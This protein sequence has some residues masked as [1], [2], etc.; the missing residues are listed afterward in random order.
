MK[1]KVFKVIIYLLLAIFILGLSVFAYCSFEGYQMYQNALKE[2]SI[3]ERINEI[4]SKEDYVTIDKIP[5]DFKYAI[6]AVEDHRFEEHGAVDV[7]AI[8]R[9]IY[10]NITEFQLIEG[11]STITQQFAKNTFFTQERK[12][13]RKMA[14]IFAAIDLEKM[15]SK[16]DIVEMY[17][18]TIYYGD[19][20]YGIGEASR[21]YFDKEPMDLTLDEITLLAGLPNA[22]S[23]YSL[24]NSPELARERQL[25]VIY[26]MEAYGF[27]TEEQVN[28]LK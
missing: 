15:Y 1:K 10:R 11:G 16:D 13:T 9:A 24:S 27:L 8:M 5:K 3:E 19:G 18:N 26:A 7:V 14:E 25:Q 17:I 22:P 2:K 4:R 21:G 28:S 20:Y 6:I 12:F 23:V